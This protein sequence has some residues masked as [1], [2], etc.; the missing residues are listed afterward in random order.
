MVTTI[1]TVT[2][3]QAA[4]M[5]GLSNAAIRQ[6]AQRGK[7]TRIGKRGRQRIYPL[8]EVQALNTTRCANPLPNNTSG[9]YDPST[10]T[11]QHPTT[12]PTP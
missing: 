4:V 12:S 2:T 5:L 6:L 10:W 9:H 11:P 7:L 3:S 1:P 8:A